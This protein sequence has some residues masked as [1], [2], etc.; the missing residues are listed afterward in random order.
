MILNTKGRDLI[1][2]VEKCLDTSI[3]F[4]KI[5]TSERKVWGNVFVSAS[6]TLFFIVHLQIHW[7]QEIWKVDS[8]RNLSWNFDNLFLCSPRNLSWK[9]LWSLLLLSW[10]FLGW[11]LHNKGVGA[12]ITAG[13]GQNSI[14]HPTAEIWNSYSPTFCPTPKISNNII[15]TSC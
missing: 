14:F 11:N 4:D 1:Y 3:K 10:S 9:F 5:K 7:F 13:L 15:F 12:L 6:V 8:H 2:M